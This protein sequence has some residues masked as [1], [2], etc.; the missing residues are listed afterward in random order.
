MHYSCAINVFEG[1]Y[2]LLL[3]FFVV[4]NLLIRSSMKPEVEEKNGET[5]Q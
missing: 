2:P 5:Q 4:I 1:I 3:D